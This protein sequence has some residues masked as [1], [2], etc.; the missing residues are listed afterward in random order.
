MNTLRKLQDSHELDDVSD[1]SRRQAFVQALSE[2]ARPLFE[3]AAS[4]ARNHDLDVVVDLVLEHDSPRLILAVSRPGEDAVSSY[5][6]VANL[7]AQRMLHEE[8]YADSGDIHRQE[9]PL[10]SVNEKVIDTRLANFFRKGFALPLDYI[11]E[12]HPIGFW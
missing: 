8:F 9:S 1:G 12:R 5:S 6:L 2:K 11:N 4:Y 3:E 7:A 10:A